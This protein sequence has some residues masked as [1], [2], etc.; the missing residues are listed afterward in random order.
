MTIQIDIKRALRGYFIRESLESACVE[1][2]ARSGG[3]DD[4]ARL[5]AELAKQK[6]AI[7]SGDL[8]AFYLLD[9][10]YHSLLYDLARMPSARR[11]VESAKSEV[12]R[13][14]GL[15]SVYRFCRP[16]SVLLDEHAEIK[17]AALAGDA[18]RA[19]LAI[20]NHLSGMNEAIEAVLKEEKLWGL[21]NRINRG[22]GQKW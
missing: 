15:K 17:N 5:D 14:K 1:R 13:L 12:D 2:L 8:D 22:T 4:F 6:T 9:N 10:D 18:R 11:L 20:K 21:F 19:R 3:G 7:E 16:E